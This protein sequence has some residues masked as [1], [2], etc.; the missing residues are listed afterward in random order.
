R[1][2]TGVPRIRRVRSLLAVCEIALA[3]MLLIGS[4]LM[5]KSFQRL[6]DVNPGFNTDNLLTMSVALPFV[7]YQDPAKQNAFFE[8]ALDRIRALPGVVAAGAC[9][10]LPPSYRQQGTGIAVAGRPVDTSQQPPEALFMPATPGFLEALG[11]PLIKGRNVTA[12]DTAGSPPVVVI[13]QILARQF[14][15]N[16]NP[17]G[18]RL[19]FEG[20]TWEIVGVVG[21][22]KY[23]GLG[24]PI[25]PQVYVPFAQ[26]PFPG[27]RL[28][29]RT[30]V[31]PTSLTAA[32]RNQIQAVDSDQGPTR[33]A[34]MNQLLSESVAQPRFN[35]FLIALFSIVAFALAAVGIYGVISY[36]VTQRTSEIGIRLALG[37]QVGD[38]WRLILRQGA[39]LTV[40]GLSLGLAGA[41]ALTR[42]LTVLLFEVTPTDAATYAIVSALVVLVST[43]A[44]LI[45]SRRATRVDPLTALRHE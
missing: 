32:I 43:L 5:L 15:A 45:P 39:G 3:V 37:A 2:V 12:T 41:F 26:R 29:V 18:Q 7:H 24:G 27:M 17:L 25:G 33:I 20:V 40:A 36:D 38:I 4:G 42:F 1:N 22:A 8:R 10:S 16:Q 44:C 23:E 28:V 13:N 34:T 35:S 19:N 30:T 9:T 21:D 11:V 6:T 31:E 14:F